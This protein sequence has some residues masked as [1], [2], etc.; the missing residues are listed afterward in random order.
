MKTQINNL[1]K[2]NGCQ[3][4]LQRTKGML[5]Q[6]GSVMFFLSNSLRW[7]GARMSNMPPG[8]DYSWYL[9]RLQEPEHCLEHE[10]FTADVLD[11]CGR[12]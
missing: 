11:L 4:Q 10:V 2:L 7:A 6:E 9:F 1:A 8:F 12:K 3:I 5:V